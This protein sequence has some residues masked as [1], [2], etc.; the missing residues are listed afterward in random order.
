M[1]LSCTL[2]GTRNAMTSLNLS[3]RVYYVDKL[4]NTV[5]MIFYC[6]GARPYYV[7]CRSFLLLILIFM[8]TLSLYD[9]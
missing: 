7:T 8:A 6:V 4:Q 9:S 2:E 1:L 3:S 5:L